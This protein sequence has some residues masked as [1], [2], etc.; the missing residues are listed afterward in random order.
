LLHLL[1]LYY[2]GAITAALFLKNFVGE[3]PWT[4]IDIAGTARGSKPKHYWPV[5]GTGFGVRLMLE[6]LRKN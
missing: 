4:H 2:V 5:Y 6:W 1:T 3:T